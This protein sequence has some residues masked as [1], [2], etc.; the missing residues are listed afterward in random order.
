[1]SSLSQLLKIVIATTPH[2]NTIPLA[3]INKLDDMGAFSGH[4]AM[5]FIMTTAVRNGAFSRF[6]ACGAWN[7]DAKAEI[8]RLIAHTGF[9]PNLTNLVFSAYAEAMQWIPAN[10]QKLQE[11]IVSEP[12]GIYRT[13]NR[14]HHTQSS[15]PTIS[16]NREKEP[17]RGITIEN[18]TTSVIASNKISLAATLRRTAPLGSGKLGYALTDANGNLIAS[19]IITTMTVTSPSVVPVT[20]TIASN[21]APATITLCVS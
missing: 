3:T 12:Q 11:S 19:G 4:P 5:R 21:G 7:S 2:Q 16:I 10:A 13:P 1:M 8:E 9:Q 18:A 15:P 14:Q 17:Y 6:A 20:A